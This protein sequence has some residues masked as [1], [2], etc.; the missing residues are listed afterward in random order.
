M[1]R[2][3][4]NLTGIRIRCGGFTLAELLVGSV[5]LS[6]TLL[7]VYAL[8]WQAMRAEGVTALRWRYRSAAEGIVAHLADAVEQAVNL[9]QRPTFVAEAGGEEG[10]LIC[11]THLQRRRYHWRGDD[12]ARGLALSM[13]ARPFAGTRDLSQGAIANQPDGAPPVEQWDHVASRRIADG[14]EQIVVRFRPVNE[15]NAQW[16]DNWEG[17]AGDVVIWI[18]VVVGGQLAERVI[19]PRANGNIGS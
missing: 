9:P 7:G 14:V 4:D 13:Q 18:Q 8:F 1:V 10:A 12:D 3:R 17:R 5:V 19:F 2:E 15:A 6:M 11:Q 16:R